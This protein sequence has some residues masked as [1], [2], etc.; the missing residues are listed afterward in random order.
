FRTGDETG[1][2]NVV[3]QWLDKT[4]VGF[5]ANKRNVGRLQK[6]TLMV[7]PQDATS[8]RQGR[9]II[10]EMVKEIAKS[11]PWINEGDITITETP[12]GIVLNDPLS[13]LG[14]PPITP[15]YLRDHYRIKREQ[16]ARE[17]EALKRQEAEE[18][19][20]RYKAEQERRTQSPFGGLDPST[21][22]LEGA[23][24]FRDR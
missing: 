24:G 8:W 6:R 19:I 13:S 10:N 18:K 21:G 4:T 9:D 11:R 23:A 17:A 3:K 20:G 2:L 15:S 16:E 5:E 14:L 12:R 7:D 1:A 22:T